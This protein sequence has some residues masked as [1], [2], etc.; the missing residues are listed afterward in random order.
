MRIIHKS[1][2]TL[3]LIATLT[4]IAA[5]A[6]AG[7]DDASKSHLDTMQ[8]T[9]DAAG[10]LIYRGAVFA[11]HRGSAQPLFNYERRVTSVGAIMT[12]AHI[13]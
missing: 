8:K 11:Q 13:T 3:V 4:T 7:L 1:L 2:H 12:A 6:H 10:T 9:P 5:A